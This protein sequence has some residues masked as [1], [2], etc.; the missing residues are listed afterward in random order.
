MFIITLLATI[1]LIAGGWK[2]ALAIA[3]GAALS[4]V[5]QWLF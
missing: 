3:I 1:V 5:A 4:G 2:L